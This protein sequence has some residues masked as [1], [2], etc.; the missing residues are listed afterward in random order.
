MKLN[1]ILVLIWII[2][3]VAN[4]IVADDAHTPLFYNKVDPPKGAIFFESFDEGWKDR[5][6]PSQNDKYTLGIIK[7]ELTK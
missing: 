5:W 6:I 2:G 7:R 4:L 3:I 1:T